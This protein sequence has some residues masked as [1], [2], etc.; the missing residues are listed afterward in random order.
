MLCVCVFGVSCGGVQWGVSY[1]T[2]YIYIISSLFTI[3]TYILSLFIRHLYYGI[4]T[5]RLFFRFSSF[6]SFSS[7]FLVFFPSF[8]SFFFFLSRH[9][10]KIC[11]Y[12]KIFPSDDK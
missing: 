1:F 4:F 5:F 11:I 10:H 7:L 9:I 6:F 8:L 2:V 3:Y 12:N